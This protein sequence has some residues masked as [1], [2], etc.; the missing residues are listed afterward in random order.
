L[1][2]ESEVLSEGF[3]QVDPI[4]RK[5]YKVLDCVPSNEIKT[6]TVLLREVASVP[7]IKEAFTYPEQTPAIHSF[8]ALNDFMVMFTHV[9]RTGQVIF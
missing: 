3:R 7:D 9:C 5:L 2:H 6:S 4:L 1:S 8:S